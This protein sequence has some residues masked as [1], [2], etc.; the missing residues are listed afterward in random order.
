MIRSN[1]ALEKG[2]RIY[3]KFMFWIILRLWTKL[4]LSKDIHWGPWA[5]RGPHSRVHYD[6]FLA[7]GGWIM[8]PK[9]NN[10]PVAVFLPG[11]A[12]VQSGPTNNEKC[13]EDKITENR[14]GKWKAGW[15]QEK[16]AWSPHDPAGSYSS[17]SWASSCRALRLSGSPSKLPI[18][19][20][21]QQLKEEGIFIL[22]ADAFI[23]RLNWSQL[24]LLCHWHSGRSFT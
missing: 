1:W 22:W 10:A 7:K 21:S 5:R 15:S 20:A 19:R 8:E 13:L 9:L 16:G 6:K 2:T 24:R 18:S 4:M 12:T 11:S 14:R 23:M 17:T 3:W